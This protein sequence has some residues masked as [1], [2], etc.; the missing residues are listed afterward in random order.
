MVAPVLPAGAKRE[1]CVTFGL[2]ETL[3]MVAGLIFDCRLTFQGLTKTKGIPGNIS[4][5]ISLA[6][7]T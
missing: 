4:L 3:E 1:T 6:A 7:M 5:V 2:S